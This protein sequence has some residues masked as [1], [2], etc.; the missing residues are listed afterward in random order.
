MVCWGFAWRWFGARGGLAAGVAL[1]LTPWLWQ[2][3]RSA[4][5]EPLHNLWVAVAAFCAIELLVGLLAA[6]GVGTPTVPGG[7]TG[8]ASP[9][10]GAARRSVGVSAALAAVGLAAAVAGA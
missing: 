8:Q 10:A 3:G 5:I 9:R 1:A 6:A 7:R 4:E 2:S